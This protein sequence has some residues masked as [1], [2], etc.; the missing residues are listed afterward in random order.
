VAVTS[1]R[2]TR[3]RRPGPA[4][5]RSATA[6]LRGIVSSW[7]RL[8]ERA[9]AQ[10][11]HGTR[12]AGLLGG[13]LAAA[14]AN[15][16]ELPEDRA[17]TMF[18]LYDGGG[19]TAL[20][21]AV[22]IRKSLFDRVSL[23]GSYFVDMVSNASIDVVTTASPYHET[24]KEGTLGLDYVYHDSLISLSG[25]H[26]KEPDYTADSVSVDVTQDVFG[27]MTT[28]SM[29]YTRGW[30]TVGKQGSPDFSAQANHWQYRLGVTQVLTPRWLMSLNLESVSDDGYLQ[31]PYRVA[32]VFGAAVPERD[33]NTR[34]GRAALL[35]LVGDIG[36]RTAVRVQY[37]YFW[38]T[39]SIGAHTAELGLTRH[40]GDRWLVDGYVRYYTQSKALFYSNDFTTSMTYMS[41]NRALSDFWDTG[42][43]LKASYSAGK[44]ASRFDVKVTAAYQWLRFQYRDFTDI[45]TGTLYSFNANV[46]EFFVSATY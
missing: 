44:I 27:G 26:S 15:G 35:R 21:P 40:F 31:S 2:L 1:G 37:R 36:S 38:D 33:P 28:V 17:D 30:D 10:G 5:G 20:G 22:L 23:T 42:P 45:R 19:V 46:A 16:A 13:V 29:G 41:R 9:R 3:A 18:H 11:A 24:R 7:V 39:W 14:R 34:T 43:G 12:L 8:R 6:L 25:T 4:F 32:R